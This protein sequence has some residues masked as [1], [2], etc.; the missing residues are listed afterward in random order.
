MGREHEGG[1]HLIVEQV[2]HP[3]S[4]HRERS[5]G[6]TMS[7]GYPTADETDPDLVG[8]GHARRRNGGVAEDGDS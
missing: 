1:L 5:K 8:P 7:L 3:G 6:H 4:A 2:L